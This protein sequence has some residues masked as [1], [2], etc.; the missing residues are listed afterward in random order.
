MRLRSR[1]M[2]GR[3]R[4]TAQTQPAE[5]TAAEHDP[6]APKG[7]P[8]PSRKEAESA[9]KSSIRTPK[10]TKEGKQ[11]ARE[12]DRE[13]RARTRA[14]MMAGDERYMPARDRG[15][16]RKFVRDY[17]DSR[18]TLAEFFIFVAIGVILLGFIN[19]PALQW[20]ISMGF[21]LFTTLIVLDLVIMLFQMNR[22]ARAE[23]PDKAE[24]KGITLYAALR[25]LQFRRLRL[26]PPRVNRRGLPIEPKTKK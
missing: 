10:N 22:R 14:G 23:F 21:F 13:E 2:F 6:Q 1:F 15:P 24:R 18:F 19:N 12:R 7:R 11:A 26:P 20:Y 9:R 3:K 5:G 25:V 16:A 4:D 8:T 17:V